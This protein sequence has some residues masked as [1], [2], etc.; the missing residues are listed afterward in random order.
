MTA[1]KEWFTV[2]GLR[3]GIVSGVDLLYYPN[4][5]VIILDQYG[6]VSPMEAENI[7]RYLYNEGFL[8]RD[9]VALEV[10]KN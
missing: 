2:N 5:K 10:V 4:Y 6:D 7:V 9:D 1:M 8:F 3:I